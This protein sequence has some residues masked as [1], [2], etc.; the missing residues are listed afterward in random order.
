M[1]KLEPLFEFSV[2]GL[3]YTV[4]QM[5]TTLKCGTNVPDVQEH[6]FLS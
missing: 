3:L 1:M 5:V 4:M 6:S 2:H